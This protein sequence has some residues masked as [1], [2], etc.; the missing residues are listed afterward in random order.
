LADLA[1]VKIAIAPARNGEER[2]DPR[3]VRAYFDKHQPLTTRGKFAL[4]RAV[5]LEGDRADAQ[6][7]VREAWR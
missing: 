7:L 4:A 2:L 3:T 5:L 6:S 1:A